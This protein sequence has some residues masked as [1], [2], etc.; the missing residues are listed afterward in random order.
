M[1]LGTK[2]DGTIGSGNAGLVPGAK[3]GKFQK[4]CKDFQACNTFQFCI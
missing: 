4:G 2:D 1:V 3:D